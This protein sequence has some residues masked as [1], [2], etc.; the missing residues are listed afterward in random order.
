LGT[1]TISPR[2]HYGTV[3]HALR[4]AQGLTYRELCARAG[5]RQTATLSTL[6]GDP[7]HMPQPRTLTAVARAL[8]TTRAQMERWIP[9]SDRGTPELLALLRDLHHLDAP[10]QARLTHL[11]RVVLDAELNSRR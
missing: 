3:V 11:F 5:L 8:G 10:T 4:R 7:T 6:E 2:W 9:V 1:R